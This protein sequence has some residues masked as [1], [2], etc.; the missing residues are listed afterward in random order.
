MKLDLFFPWA[1]IV[2]FLLLGCSKE[3]ETVGGKIN[4]R[5]AKSGKKLVEGEETSVAP[6]SSA[7]LD[8]GAKPGNSPEENSG[9]I[10]G[11][12]EVSEPAQPAIPTPA[13]IQQ[14][15]R[16]A[17]AGEANAQVDLG[18]IH[19]A[20]LGVPVNKKAAEILWRNAAKAGH[21]SAIQNLQM[22]HT[23]PEEGVSFFGT[24][25]KGTRFVFVIDKSGSMGDKK[26]FVRAKRELIKTLRA[27]PKNSRFMIYFFDEGS[28]QMPVN[29]LM[30]AVPKNIKWAEN[31]VNSV[32]MG[33][34]TD[35]RKA[36]KSGFS[37]K[38]DTVWLL[39]DGVFNNESGVLAQIRA[40]NPKSIMRINTLAIMDRGGEKVLQ[41]IAKE[42]DGTYRFVQN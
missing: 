41:Q 19:F 11:E 17:Q 3:S 20:G 32:G 22:L 5:I 31:W 38:P 16:R 33:G 39:T 15:I 4:P 18:N 1:L 27:L 35:P 29:N 7:S 10:G 26:K 24:K 21:P 42:N 28:E 34:G 36:L 37:L 25:S 12:D 8:S 9:S 13:E 40:A 23:K 2:I 14:L 30:A 6:N